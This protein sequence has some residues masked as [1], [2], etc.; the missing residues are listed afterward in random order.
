MMD[1]L[2]KPYAATPR[3][4]SPAARA[5]PGGCCERGDEALRVLSRGFRRA[6]PVRFKGSSLTFRACMRNHRTLQTN[7]GGGSAR[8]KTPE[9]SLRMSGNHANGRHR[10]GVVRDECFGGGP[11]P[12]FVRVQIRSKMSRRRRSCL[13]PRNR[14]L[15]R[16]DAPRKRRGHRGATS[17]AIGWRD[18]FGGRFADLDRPESRRNQRAARGC[19]RRFVLRSGPAS[20]PDGSTKK[21][22]GRRRSASIAAQGGASGAFN[23]DDWR[24]AKERARRGRRVSQRGG[25]HWSNAGARRLEGNAASPLRPR[26]VAPPAKRRDAKI[27]RARKGGR[28]RVRTAGPSR[29]RR[30]AGSR[31]RRRRQPV[32]AAA[33]PSFGGS[34]HGCG[35]R[36]PQRR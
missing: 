9:P 14:V 19:R 26:A 21:G 18:I 25:W 1:V 2:A 23:E 10:P 3:R 27:R 22:T 15:V 35:P 12:R 34:D 8:V 11:T 29:P 30:R 16:R 5:S 28:L 17:A 32:R 4:A 24:A 36:S 13:P 20:A 7:V 33:S 31:R 6:P